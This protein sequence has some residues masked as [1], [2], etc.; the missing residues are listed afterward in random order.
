MASDQ[1]PLSRSQRVSPP[2]PSLFRKNLS[3]SH[4]PLV[5]PPPLPERKYS[6]Q[7]SDPGCLRPYR[8]IAYKYT[9]KGKPY[10]KLARRRIPPIAK[11]L[12]KQMYTALVEYAPPPPFSLPH[13]LFRK[14]TTTRKRER[15]D[16]LKILL[17]FFLIFVSSS[18]KKPPHPETTC[19]LYPKSAPKASS[20][21]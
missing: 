15:E 6:N 3:Y 20:H 1:N 21:P 4:P 12:H 9:I 10:P 18:L 13:F 7:L 14:S 19:T 5:P 16:R 2:F 8:T 17:V 11:A